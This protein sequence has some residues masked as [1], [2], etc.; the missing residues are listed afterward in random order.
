MTRL[1]PITITAFAMLVLVVVA[2]IFV[3]SRPRHHPPR[4]VVE[5]LPEE[6]SLSPAPA[7]VIAVVEEPRPRRTPPAA[8]PVVAPPPPPAADAR[9]PLEDTAALFKRRGLLIAAHKKQ[10]VFEA[11]EKAFEVVKA[12]QATRGAIRQINEEFAKRIETIPMLSPSGHPVAEGSGAPV[13][14]YLG[15]ENARREAIRGVLDADSAAAFENAERNA[16]IG[17]RAHYRRQWGQELRAKA[18]WPS[19]QPTEEQ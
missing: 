16:E 14:T 1:S 12:S 7:Q 6:P 4:A 10:L 9:R 19:V 11:D 13:D 8:A 5:D 3:V 15:A 17:V 2:G 18:P